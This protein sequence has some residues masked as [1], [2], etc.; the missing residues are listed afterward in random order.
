MP[1]GIAL[2][3]GG[4]PED[5]SEDDMES[6]DSYEEEE[7]EYLKTAFPELEDDPERLEA[8]QMAIQVCVEKHMRKMKGM[9]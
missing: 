2:L 5:E 9:R 8:L 1:K 4:K 3:L 6:E 7:A